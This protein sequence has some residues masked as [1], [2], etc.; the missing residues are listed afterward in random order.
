MASAATDWIFS[1]VRQ[2]FDNISFT[3]PDEEPET[4]ASLGTGS[5]DEWV[6]PGT[7]PYGQ[8]LNFITPR[9]YF[10]RRNDWTDLNPGDDS[11]PDGLLA[12]GFYQESSISA[13]VGVLRI[14]PPSC[15]AP[16][17][18]LNG[19]WAVDLLDRVWEYDNDG[20][21]SIIRVT[22]SFL[23]TTTYKELL[24]TTPNGQETRYIVSENDLLKIQFMK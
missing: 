20:R 24:W 19:T 3:M 17:G 5:F 15:P 21:N 2:T 7:I 1:N 12:G 16:S 18:N 6:G 4:W 11:L 23:L 14:T 13:L 9:V 8:T 22:E 10:E